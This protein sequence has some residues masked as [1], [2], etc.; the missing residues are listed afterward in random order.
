MTEI[1]AITKK[2]IKLVDYIT[3]GNEKLAESIEK[4]NKQIEE[5]RL[6]VKQ[7]Q[8][9]MQEE[10]DE[11]TRATREQAQDLL[12]RLERA[13]ETALKHIEDNKESVTSENVA[14]L[15][16]LAQVD[17]TSEELKK[18]AE[19]Y[20]NNDLAL[21]LLEK[22]AK[23]QKIMFALPETEAEK[24]KKEFSKVRTIVNSY[25]SFTPNVR[26]VQALTDNLALKLER[27]SLEEMLTA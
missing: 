11:F 20:S 2:A 23:E 17:T 18:Y 7:G 22:I 25:K 8:E 6:G 16:L 9:M 10:K 12:E 21:R 19:K 5:E 3:Q 15:Q 14:E 1:K 13:E 24:T 27:A 26:N 4:Y